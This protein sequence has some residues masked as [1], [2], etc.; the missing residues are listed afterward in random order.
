MVRSIRFNL[1]RKKMN[2]SKNDCVR[3]KLLMKHVGVEMNAK[4]RK[5]PTQR[6][7]RFFSNDTF[8]QP[9]DCIL[10]HHFNKLEK[11]KAFKGRKCKRK[12]PVTH[13]CCAVHSSDDAY[14]HAHT[15]KSHLPVLSVCVTSVSVHW[16]K[17][18][19]NGMKHFFSFDKCFG[20]NCS[21]ITNIKKPIMKMSTC[22]DCKNEKA[23]PHKK[24]K[25]GV[26]RLLRLS[27][28]C[29]HLKMGKMCL[30]FVRFSQIRM[31]VVCREK[32]SQTLRFNTLI[33]WA[34]KV[35]II[36]LKSPCSRSHTHTKWNSVNFWPIYIIHYSLANKFTHNHE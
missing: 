32:K 20:G 28:Y 33:C 13:I 5:K 34:A 12:E 14:S 6:L 31:Q 3:S 9:K 30:R 35:I 7:S 25:I 21:W 22:Q 11:S 4:E 2:R 26:K 16:D 8:V 1:N 15:Q 23:A 24:T 29:N 19:A 36:K 18:C 27:R 10:L 17:C